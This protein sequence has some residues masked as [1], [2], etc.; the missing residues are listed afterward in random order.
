MS[1]ENT[2]SKLLLKLRLDH[3]QSVW[4]LFAANH[5]RLDDIT[6]DLWLDEPSLFFEHF[7]AIVQDQTDCRAFVILNEGQVIGF[8]D[9]SPEA[10]STRIGYLI[11]KDYEGQGIM[12]RYLP[13]VIAQ[14]PHPIEARIFAENIRSQKLVERLGFLPHHDENNDYT[15]WILN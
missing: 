14:L 11:D 4:E 6:V 2:Q 3:L 8:I 12:S 1:C 13:D 7:S 5:Q 15:I 10:K 9:S